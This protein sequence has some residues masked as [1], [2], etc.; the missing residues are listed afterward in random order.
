MNDS[1]IE[2]IAEILTNKLVTISVKKFAID[3]PKYPI[4]DPNK[5]KNKTAYSIY[6]FIPCISSTLID[7]LFL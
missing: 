3:R 7:P 6:P 4:I 5:G 1:Q 2:I